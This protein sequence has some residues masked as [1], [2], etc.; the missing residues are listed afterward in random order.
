MAPRLPRRGGVPP[1]LLAGRYRVSYDA[2]LT[3]RPEVVTADPVLD[4]LAALEA[5]DVDLVYLDPPARGRDAHELPEVGAGQGAAQDD[6]VTLGD[7]L[8]HGVVVVGE[9][10]EERRVG[11]ECRSRWSPY[12]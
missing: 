8:L 2:E 5:V 10:S 1:R 3:H 4:G 7:H 6:G 9:R 12:H 11:K